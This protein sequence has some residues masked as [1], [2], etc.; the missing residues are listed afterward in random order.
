MLEGALQW[1]RRIIQ[2]LLQELQDELEQ[3]GFEIEIRLEL[4]LTDPS[5][6]VHYELRFQTVSDYDSFSAYKIAVMVEVYVDYLELKRYFNMF[7]SYVY[8]SSGFK[9]VF[10]S[11]KSATFENASVNEKKRERWIFDWME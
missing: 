1:Y 4:I 10:T 6:K 3:G 2:G 11:T 8:F 5:Y 7:C 9:T